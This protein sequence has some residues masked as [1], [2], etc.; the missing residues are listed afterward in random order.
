MFLDYNE[1]KLEINSRKTAENFPNSWKLN[2]VFLNNT[3]FKTFLR[4]VFEIS[5]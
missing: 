1:T 4:E 2:N 5:F 3:W